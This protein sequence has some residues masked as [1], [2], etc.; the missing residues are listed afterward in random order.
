MTNEVPCIFLGHHSNEHWEPWRALDHGLKVVDQVVDDLE[1][2]R[3][4]VVAGQAAEQRLHQV[5]HEA[6]EDARGFGGVEVLDFVVPAFAADLFQRRFEAASDE[7]FVEA[8]GAMGLQR[9]RGRRGR[10]PYNFGLVFGASG[11]SLGQLSFPPRSRVRFKLGVVR[12]Q[13]SHELWVNEELLSTD[14]QLIKDAQGGQ[15]LQVL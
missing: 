15:R 7:L 2:A 10:R 5:V 4:A 12:R 8:W 14:R 1:L 13:E 6:G 9:M 3:G 11:A